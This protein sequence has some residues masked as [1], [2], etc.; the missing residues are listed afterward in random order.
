MARIK[1]S[2][3]QHNEK[4]QIMNKTVTVNISGFVFYIE[5]EAFNVLSTYLNR[6]KSIFQ[7][8]ES[9][10]E[11]I[12][13]VEARIAELFKERLDGVKEVVNMKD[14]DEVIQ[15][16]GKPEDYVEDGAY[17]QPS[18]DSYA[19]SERNDS[20]SKKLYRDPDDKILGGV[21]TG[22]GHYFGL[23]AALIRIAFILV[24]L[25]GTAGGWIY[26]IL[27]IVV[28]KA[29]STAEKLKMKGEPITVESIKKKVNDIAGEENVQKAQSGIQNLLNGLGDLITAAAKVIGKIAA[30]LF[31]I[32]FGMMAIGLLIGLVALIVSPDSNFF[33]SNLDLELTEIMDL[34]FHG[35]QNFYLLAIGIALLFLAPIVGLF[36]LSVRL[37]G[38]RK[39]KSRPLTLGVLTAFFIGII[40]TAAGAIS[41]QKHYRASGDIEEIEVIPAAEIEELHVMLLPDDVFHSSINLNHY[42]HDYELMKTDEEYLYNGSLIELR[43]RS[44]ATDDYILTITKESQGMREIEAINFAEN[45]QHD[46]KLDGDTLYLAPYFYTP[47]EDKFRWQKIEI[48]IA[49]PDN[50]KISLDKNT[51]RIDTRGVRSGKSYIYIDGRRETEGYQID[52][53][54]TG[55]HKITIEQEDGSFRLDIQKDIEEEI[56]EELEEVKETIE[57]IAI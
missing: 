27:W 46:I 20:Q 49:V 36:Y 32:L 9:S 26:I 54:G 25:F 56:K 2:S 4:T 1:Q 53:E 48:E 51:R 38:G 5:E 30:V 31:S 39:Y 22:L 57:S 17:E 28:P 8:E 3:K 42:H 7:S 19:K 24:F 43:T 10:D 41:W 34:G 50:K 29:E 6:I 40:M 21:C 18:S 14:V 45:I 23:D 33:M 35:A 44:S 15:I 55:H 52:S 12:D 37:I 47:L 13:D 16:M 11:I